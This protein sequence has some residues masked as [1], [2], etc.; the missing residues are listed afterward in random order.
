MPAPVEILRLV[1]RFSAQKEAY[2]S[3][4]YNETQVRR[5]FLDPF[6]DALGWDVF[7]RQGHAEAYKD[8]IHEDAVRVGGIVKAPD[9]CFRIGRRRIFFVEAKKPSVNVKDE[10][11]PAYQL[12]RYAWSAG[13]P[14]SILTDFHELAVYDCRLKPAP[15]DKSSLGR[16]LYLTW[17]EYPKK[18]EELAALF[19]REAVLKGSFERWAASGRKKGT[20]DVDDA[21][22]AEIEGW[23]DLLAR[24]IALRNPDLLTQEL[25]FAVQRTID[26]IIFLRICED[27][28]IEEYGRLQALQNGTNIHDRLKVLFQRADERYNSGLFHFRPEKGRAEAPDELTPRL[29]L[30]DKPL[31]EIIRG[32]YYPESPYEFSVL[33][34]DILG[35]VYER[36]LGK[37]IRLTAGHRAVVEEK[38]EV[39]KAGGVYYTPTYIVEY[40]VKNTV[41]KLLEEKTPKQAAKLRILDPACGSGFFLIGAYQYLLDWHR[42]WYAAHDPEKHASGRDPAI[43]SSP[44]RAANTKENRWSVSSTS[45]IGGEVGGGEIPWRLTTAKR[46][47]ILLNNIHGVDIDPQAVEVTKLSLLLTVLEGEDGETLSRQLRIFHERALPDLGDNIKCGN[48]LIGPDY[49]DNKLFPSP[50]LLGKGRLSSPSPPGGEGRGE[51]L[52]DDE[53]RRINPFDW[54]AEFPEIMK[55]GGFDAVI[56]NPPYIRIQTLKEWAPQEVEFY[57]QA[58]RSAAAGNYDIY[59]V[60]VER[61]LGLL[62]KEGRLGFILPHKF[63]NAKYGA[64]LR[65]IVAAGKHL[66]KVVHFGD[67]Q[68]FAGATTYTCLFFLDKAGRKEFEFERISNLDAWRASGEA[69]RGRIKSTSAGAAEWNFSVGKGRDLMDK[70]AAMPVKLGGVTPGMFVGLQTSADTV[71]LFKEYRE[72]KRGIT[73]VRSKELDEW[74]AVESSLLKKV[75]RSGDIDR[76]SAMPMALVLFPYEVRDRTARLFPVAVMSSRFP[77]CWSYLNRNRKLLEGREKGAFKDPTWYRFGRTQNLGMWEQ[78]KLLVPYMITRLASYPD[79]SDDFYFINVTT[80]GYGITVDESRC[81]LHYLAGLLNS[82]LLDFVFKQASTT[83]HGG[84]FAANKQYI[85]NLPIRTIDFSDPADKARHDKMVELVETMLALHKRLAAART[86]DDRTPLR[87]RIEATDTQIDRLVYDLYSLTPAEIA[88]IEEN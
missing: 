46:K 5:E 76:Y 88:L 85:E 51:G 48:S 12:R 23:R 1:E 64:G 33:P 43:C 3:G 60:F 11:G 74:V 16:V 8:V 83:F 35:S 75:V 55:A 20:A 18:W 6:F 73:E 44:L 32:L 24:T 52:D 25:N 34:A 72:S 49:Y 56:G 84:Y 62:S 38:P 14:L 81:T 80:G 65:E 58:Y 40:I 59:V 71:F 22:L 2:L 19:S 17:D 47:E 21:F 50:R 53:L 86:E 39:R 31:K 29:E 77:L 13:L 41:G 61:G 26:R 82:R 66:S 79:L 70:L 36:F 54:K 28:G 4:A 67:Q 78:P 9:Y 63:F 42:D 15:T 69:E 37:V 45:P 30:D 10:A 27:R 87:R 7:N 57:K 68:V